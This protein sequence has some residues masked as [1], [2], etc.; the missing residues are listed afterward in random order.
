MLKYVR[1]MQLLDINII[2]RTVYCYMSRNASSINADSILIEELNFFNYFFIPN[3]RLALPHIHFPQF[4]IIVDN[5]LEPVTFVRLLK[6]N[7]QCF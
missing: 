6:H 4:Q 5:F 1:L 2:Y 7:G 3:P